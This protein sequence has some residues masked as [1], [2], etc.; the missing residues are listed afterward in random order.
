MRFLS[1]CWY[2]YR[3]LFLL[4]LGYTFEIRAFQCFAHVGTK[5]SHFLLCLRSESGLSPGD[6]LAVA[7]F[8]ILCLSFLQFVGFFVFC[9]NC[10]TCAVSTTEFSV[11]SQPKET[12][13]SRWRA[14]P[15]ARGSYS[16]VAAGS[17]GNDYDL[18][19]QPITP[20]PAI[21]GAPQV[22]G[23]RFFLEKPQTV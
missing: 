16:Y 13:V 20:G 14:D 6:A 12:V 22:R 17:S 18:M 4:K 9:P 15:W 7:S 8:R 10:T 23:V 2:F 11:L 5:M 19:A 3:V 1:R 21:P